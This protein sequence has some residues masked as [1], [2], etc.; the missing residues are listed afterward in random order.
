MLSKFGVTN[1]KRSV[2]NANHRLI[3]I[4]K[5]VMKAAVF[6][7]PLCALLDYYIPLI[8]PRHK[9]KASIHFLLMTKFSQRVL[10]NSMENVKVNLDPVT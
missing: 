9:M 3:E 2:L 5:K 4:N 6:S 8:N 7:Y 10:L 1:E